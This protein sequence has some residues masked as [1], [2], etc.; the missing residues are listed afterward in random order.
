MQILIIK[1]SSLGDIIHTLPAIT[2]AQKYIPEIKF[3]WV[4][5]KTF[6]EI[7]TWNSAV[8]KI[9][10]IQ[11]RKWRKN[12]LKYKKEWQNFKQILNSQKYDLI[13]DAQGLLKSAFIGSQTKGE[14]HGYA[15]NSVREPFASFFYHKKH[16]ISKKQHAINKIRQLFASVLDYKIDINTFPNY[17]IN[18]LNICKLL[19]KQKSLVF[20]HGTTWQTKHWLDENWIELAKIAIKNNYKIRLPY[21]NDIEYA[22]AKKISIIDKQ[23]ISIIPKTN[24]AGIANELSKATLVIGVD[25]GLAHLAAALNVPSIIL[26]S[27]TES[28]L[29]G[30]FGK[31]QIHLQTNI[32]CAPCFRKKCNDMY[33]YKSLSVDKVWQNINGK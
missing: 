18:N 1:T 27:S 30:T 5:E 3:T 14:Y 33:C 26:Y 9:I 28:G 15:Y 13:I 16:K 25:T 7:P 21:G 29:T 22:R 24:L 19:A 20:L 2:E 10:P 31:N 8:N 12:P 6:A 4:V 17:G 23:N 32:N 11:F